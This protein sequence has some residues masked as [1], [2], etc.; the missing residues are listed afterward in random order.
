[1]CLMGTPSVF[2]VRIF[3][4]FMLVASAG[5]QTEQKRRN[6]FLFAHFYTLF[7]HKNRWFTGGAG[8]AV[9]VV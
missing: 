6:I 4:K 2:P 1:M 5:L 8:A 7:D 3:N 9:M